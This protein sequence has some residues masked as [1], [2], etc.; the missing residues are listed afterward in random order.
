MF[1]EPPAT[2]LVD[3]NH[4][5]SFGAVEFGDLVGITVKILVKGRAPRGRGE[6]FE[7]YSGKP[8]KQRTHP[9]IIL[10]GIQDGP[11]TLPPAFDRSKVASG[12]DLQNRLF[13]VQNKGPVMEPLQLDKWTVWDREG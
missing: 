11:C 12:H 10:L 6:C 9:T 13:F 2:L 4:R 5:A 8:G 1:A 7:C 3:A